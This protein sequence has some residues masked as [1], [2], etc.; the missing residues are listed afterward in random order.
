MIE[1]LNETPLLLITM[2]AMIKIHI[3]RAKIK[4]NQIDVNNLNTVLALYQQYDFM[5]LAT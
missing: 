3:F 1:V 4:D 5:C 2:R